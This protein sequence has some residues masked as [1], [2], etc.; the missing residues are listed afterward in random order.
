M[1]RVSTVE[2]LENEGSYKFINGLDNLYDD[3]DAG[4]WHTRI[5]QST[6]STRRTGTRAAA[7]SM[8]IFSAAT[9]AGPTSGDAEARTLNKGDSGYHSGSTKVSNTWKHQKSSDQNVDQWRHRCERIAK[10]LYRYVEEADHGALPA[11]ELIDAVYNLS[12]LLEPNTRFPMVEVDEDSGAVSLMW[13]LP[14]RKSS[15]TLTYTNRL[16]V[17][18]VVSGPD[19]QVPS[20]E[21]GL[22]AEGQ[23]AKKL[24]DASIREF[25]VI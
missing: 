20:W 9:F 3:L 18:G 16:T 25:F 5:E 19:N 22:N 7:I 11:S 17:I 6:V 21:F 15:F 13:L 23:I 14:K 2:K 12:Y 4:Q 10:N 24:Q 1:T 8:A